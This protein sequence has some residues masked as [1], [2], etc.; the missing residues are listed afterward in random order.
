VENLSQD[1][2]LWMLI[3]AMYGDKLKPYTNRYKC[4][5]DR[6]MHRVGDA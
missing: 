2:M 5:I 3:A 4:G 1:A 6:E